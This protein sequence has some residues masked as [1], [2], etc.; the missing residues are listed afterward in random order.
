M[1]EVTKESL[2]SLGNVYNALGDII[3][4]VLEAQQGAEEYKNQLEDIRNNV[5]RLIEAYGGALPEPANKK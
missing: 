4:N 5:G 3:N 1:T 2:A